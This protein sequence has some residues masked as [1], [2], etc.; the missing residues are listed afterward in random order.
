MRPACDAL[1]DD[2]LGSVDLT[3]IPDAYRGVFEKFEVF[4]GGK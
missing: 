1:K 3:V 2:L 4:R